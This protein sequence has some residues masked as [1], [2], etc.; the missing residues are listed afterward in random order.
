MSVSTAY[1]TLAEL[2]AHPSLKLAAGETA[3]DTHQKRH[4]R[5]RMGERGVF[6]HHET[7]DARS[8]SRPFAYAD[9]WHDVGRHD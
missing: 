9:V 3:D 1:A 7:L 6:L 4:I 5:A 8:I 2:R